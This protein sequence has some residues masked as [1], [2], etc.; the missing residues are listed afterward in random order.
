MS[1][2]NEDS[3]STQFRT[4]LSITRLFA[5]INNHG[6]LTLA[7]PE[8]SWRPFNE[9]QE[10]RDLVL[11]AIVTLLVQKSEI[12]AAIAQSSPTPPASKSS[13]ELL[14]LPTHGISRENSAAAE[15]VQLVEGSESLRQ[16]VLV[17]NPD[18]RDRYISHES[19]LLCKLVDH[20]QSHMTRIRQ[21]S[22]YWES[23]FEIS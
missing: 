16:V 14:A 12:L 19:P 18:R 9:A 8:A 2:T 5:A 21:A 22:N 7:G 4:I 23:C 20:G 15:A 17:S 11:N 13:L 10:G 6:N 1:R 3:L